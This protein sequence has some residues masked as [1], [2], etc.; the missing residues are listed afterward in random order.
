MAG[1]WERPGK[2]ANPGQQFS[3]GQG[4]ESSVAQETET[5]RGPGL[6]QGHLAVS[7]GAFSPSYTVERKIKKD[8]HYRGPAISNCTSGNL[9]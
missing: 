2:E 7:C 1:A 3:Q 4:K 6:A 5:L 8:D 9:S